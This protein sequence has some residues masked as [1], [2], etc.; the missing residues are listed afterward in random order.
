VPLIELGSTSSEVFKGCFALYFGALPLGYQIALL[1]SASFAFFT[2]A[3]RVITGLLLL[4]VT[5]P[6]GGRGLETSF[7]SLAL[8]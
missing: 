7:I 2:S 8:E 5:L 4:V 6:M 1:L 3:L